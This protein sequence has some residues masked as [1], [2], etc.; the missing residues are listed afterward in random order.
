M[1]SPRAQE[2]D[3]RQ[4]STSG[5]RGAFEPRVEEVRSMSPATVTVT[6]SGKAKT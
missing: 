6:S 5:M 4:I 2:G 1:S 3:G